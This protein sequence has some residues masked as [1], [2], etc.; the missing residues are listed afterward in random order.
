LP[1]LVILALAA[2]T[3]DAGQIPPLKTWIAA[4]SAAMTKGELR[5]PRPSSSR[6]VS[7]VARIHATGRSTPPCADVDGSNKYGHDV[8]KHVFRARR[9]RLCFGLKPRVEPYA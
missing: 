4:T 9:Y 1:P 3:H 5:F 6:L 2:S 8:G 7:L